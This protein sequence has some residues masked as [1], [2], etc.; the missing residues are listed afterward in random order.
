VTSKKKTSLPHICFV[1][2]NAYAALVAR[3]DIRHIG[4]AEVQQVHIARGLV[5]KGYPV[6]FITLDHNQEDRQYSDGISIYKAYR[7]DEGVPGIRFVY[8]RIARVW[9]A[10]RRANADVYYQRTSDSTT[11]IVAAFC[12]RYHRRFVF[13]LSSLKDCDPSLPSCRTLR[14]RVLY[15]YGL[16]HASKVVAQ[17]RMQ[18][19]CL[20]R[21]FGIEPVV[22]PNCIPSH[23]PSVPIVA[24]KDP[25]VLWVGRL[26]WEKRFEMLLDVAER[27]DA[28][29]FFDVLGI[30]PDMLSTTS[31]MR[32]VLRCAN[33]RMHGYVPY[34]EAMKLYIGARALICTS[35]VEGFP[36][37]FLEAWSRSIPV[38]TTFDP[39]GV[40]AANRLGLY[41][42]GIEALI[43]AVHVICFDQPLHAEIAGNAFHYY[44]EHHTLDTVIPQ[45]Q[46][47]FEDQIAS[48]G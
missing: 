31:L 47:L 34:A 3:P 7:L 37:T 23:T 41:A 21:N 22:I 10:M 4:G 16:K 35:M 13:G 26:A 39:D 12:R 30:S 19:E 43:D 48:S 32:R 46:S 15:R 9:S 42:T 2:P 25:H 45:Y 18:Q 14:E 6:S 38:A 24:N 20:R 27:C 36:N 29:I 5:A 40:V 17:T 28:R 44:Q 11:G 1:A 8:P 33:I